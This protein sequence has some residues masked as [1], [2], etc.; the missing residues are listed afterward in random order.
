MSSC[1]SHPAAVS[2]PSKSAR[3]SVDS[4]ARGYARVYDTRRRRLSTL[5]QAAP[6]TYAHNAEGGEEPM[7]LKDTAATA[8]TLTHLV[9]WIDEGRHFIGQLSMLL[10]RVAGVEQ[11]CVRLREQLTDLQRENQQLRSDR[12][13]IAEGLLK[14][15]DRLK[16]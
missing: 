13:D 9:R 15:V 4:R 12:E 7:S 1:V 6:T 10:E 14:A 11:E 5:R 2:T 3:K 16:R 8:T